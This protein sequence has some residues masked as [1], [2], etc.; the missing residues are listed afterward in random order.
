[1]LY[2]IQTDNDVYYLYMHAECAL[3][4]YFDDFLNEEI[5]KD[6][7]KMQGIY[8]TKVNADILKYIY[9]YDYE[10]KDIFIDFDKIEDISDNNLLGFFGFLKR[11]FCVQ[12]KMV[13]IANLDNKI[14]ERIKGDNKFKIEEERDGKISL[15]MGNK[16][17]YVEIQSLRKKSKI[18]I[19]EI[20]EKMIK[21]STEKCDEIHTS[22]PVYLSRYI[23]MKKMVADN[24]IL[25]RYAIYCLANKMID[26]NIISNEYN[27]NRNICLFFQTING[28]YI[29]SQIADLFNIDIVYLDHLGPIKSVHKKHFEKCIHDN[30]KYI[31]ISD[32]ICLGG[33]VGRARTIIEYCGGTVIG[34]VCLVDIKTI[35]NEDIKNRISLY[36]VSDENNKIEYTIETDLCKLCNRR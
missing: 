1:M 35:K 23:N 15:I 14:Y 19:D 11:K 29:A 6:A 5:K 31:I 16:R 7:K 27:Y 13:Y 12:N 25:L 26:G 30:K 20:V 34:E 9:E 18:I 8:S 4:I 24:S 17:E 33:E 10:S 2:S 28:G 21:N 3:H 36:T 22:S 32:V